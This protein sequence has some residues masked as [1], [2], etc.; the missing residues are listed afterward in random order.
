[1]EKL[2]PWA[3]HSIKSFSLESIQNDIVN[4]VKTNSQLNL[5]QVIA[6]SMYGGVANSFINYR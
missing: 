3:K 5:Y 2:F 4:K 1:M 6:H